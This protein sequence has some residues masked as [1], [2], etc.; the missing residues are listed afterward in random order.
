MLDVSQSDSEAELRG[1]R[2][3]AA[4]YR[5]AVVLVNFDTDQR[6][7]RFIKALRSDGQPL[8]FGYEVNDI[9]GHN[10]G[11]VGRGSQIFIRT[12]EIPPAV[13]VAIDKQQG[14]SCTITFGKEIDES[15]I[16]SVGESQ[17]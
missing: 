16:I 11:V 8:T 3:I 14:L 6:K 17:I 10:I 4:P 2:K 15:K 1:N 5:G 13:N 9:H 7:P 12:N